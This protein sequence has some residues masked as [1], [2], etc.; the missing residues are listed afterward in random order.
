MQNKV[1]AIKVVKGCHGSLDGISSPAP[2][3]LRSR[4][5]DKVHG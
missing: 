1:K 5:E 2:T 3:L 4:K